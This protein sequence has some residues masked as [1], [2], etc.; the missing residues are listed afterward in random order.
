MNLTLRREAHFADGTI[1]VLDVQGRKFL[2]LELAAGGA[3]AD[4]HDTCLPPGT[5]RLT[6]V[7]RAGGERCYSISNPTLGVWQ[8]P[9]DVPRGAV[10]DARSAVYLAAGFGVDDLV[11][12]HVAVGKVRSKVRG[13][14][15]LADTRGALNELR[16][17]I[18]GAF[19]IVLTVEE[20]L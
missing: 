16:T 10:T 8:R 17:L 15:Q 14:W 7:Q 18:G 5:Y 4:K 9:S 3:D 20:P 19:D 13:A 1:G 12:C 6:P 2:T 11:G